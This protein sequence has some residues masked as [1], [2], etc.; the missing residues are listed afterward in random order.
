M[1]FVVQ[2]TKIILF[3]NVL[4]FYIF[5]DLMREKVLWYLQAAMIS[6]HLFLKLGVGLKAVELGRGNPNIVFTFTFE[7]KNEIE[8]GKVR[9]ENEFAG[10]REIRK[11]TNSIGNM[12]NIVGLRKSKS[13]GIFTDGLE[14]TGSWRR[15]KSHSSLAFLVGAARLR[16]FSLPL[17]ARVPRVNLVRVAI[18]RPPGAWEAWGCGYGGIAIPNVQPTDGESSTESRT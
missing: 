14:S 5:L 17:G 3:S 10:Y 12:S 2:E 13:D 11:R 16:G 7:Y 9:N 18:A 15:A 8:F 4:V 6:L 1:L